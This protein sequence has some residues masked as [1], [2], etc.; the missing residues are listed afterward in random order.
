[1]LFILILFVIS[2]VVLI[3]FV[4][5]YGKKQKELKT[6]R[7][8][9]YRLYKKIMNELTFPVFRYHAKSDCMVGNKK[10]MEMCGHRKVENFKGK[11]EEWKKI[12]P[13]YKAEV[14]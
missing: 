1:M 7:F 2:L 10:F 11:A 12:H 8:Y 13:A 14:L 4:V 9:Q 5:L 6:E 3:F